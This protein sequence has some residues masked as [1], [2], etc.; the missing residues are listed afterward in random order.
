MTAEEYAFENMQ[1]C[2]LN[3]IVSALEGF[4]EMKCKRLLEIVAKEARINF[5]NDKAND[6]SIDKDSILNVVDL[7]EFCK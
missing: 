6:F 3:E 4:A 1:G 2:D 5:S 7:E